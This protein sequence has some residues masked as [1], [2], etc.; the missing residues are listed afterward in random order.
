MPLAVAIYCAFS[1]HTTGLRAA[2]QNVPKRVQLTGPVKP[3]QLVGKIDYYLDADWSKTPDE[4]ARE[5]ANGPGLF[6]P[7]TAAVPNFG[8]IKARVWLRVR[9]QNN[10]EDVTDWRIYFPENF[11]Q[12]FAVFV[13]RQGGNIDTLL[14]E[15]PTTGFHQRPIAFP[16]LVA[17]LRLAPGEKATLLVRYWS[18]GT[19]ELAVGIETAQSFNDMAN[20]RTAKNFVYYGMTMLLIIGAIL[21][22]IVFRQTV[23]AAY[24]AYATSTLLFIMHSDGVAFQFL[25]PDWPQFNS[26]ASV[27]TGSAIVIFGANYARIFLQTARFHPTLDKLLW[28][29]IGF[30]AAI[31]IASLFV[32][33]QPIK[34]GLILVALFAIALF[35]ASGLVAARTRFKQVR[36]YVLAWSGAVASAGIMTMRHWLGFEIP[37]DVQLDS[38]RIVMV[39]DAT[40]MGLAIADRYNQLRVSRQTALRD[41]LKQAQRSLAL[42]NRLHDLE[43]KFALAEEMAANRSE[44][45]ENTVHDLRQ[46][47]HALRLGI[48]DLT[49]STADNSASAHEKSEQID[50]G[51]SYLESL[52]ADHLTIADTASTSVPPPGS[53]DE[54]DDRQMDLNVILKSIHQMFQSDAAEKGVE[55]RFVP[56]SCTTSVDPLVIMRCVSNLVSN[57][58]KYTAEGRVLLGVRCSPGH[59]RIEVHDTG[60][61]M[62]GEEFKTALNRHARL[63]HNRDSA[64]GSGFGLTIVRDLAEMHHIKLLHLGDR[65]TG[66]SLALEMPRD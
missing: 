26:Y 60:T 55:F 50:A 17:P 5:S 52:I 34:K 6:K 40:M 3:A 65:K 10:T 56:T 12:Y 48:A 15:T 28:G 14:D 20:R 31:L 39:F 59:L 51:F 22:M 36:F 33:N 58:V 24:A 47:L 38:M 32:D 18:E 61:G 29:T 7:V 4:M 1:L 30:T 44:Q 45:I 16:E 11:K 43:G 37:K 63:D 23:F 19:S 53:E 21:A 27:L 66:T 62:S 49:A 9:L 42:T 57:A 8:Y 35:T 46:P 25:W 41:S 64:E 2:K 13:A 54:N